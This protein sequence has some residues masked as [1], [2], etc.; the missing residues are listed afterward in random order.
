[1][2]LKMHPLNPE[3]RLVHKIITCLK[4]KG[5]IIYP[6]DTVYGI[7]CSI[8]AS[9]AIEKICKLKH[10]APNKA[11]L[12]IIFADLKHISD[13]CKPFNTSV[14][15]TLKAYLPGPFTFILEAN[16]N[17]PK[18]LL[19]NRRTIGIRIP[20]NI[21]TNRLVK[22]LEHPIIT[23]SLP[24]DPELTYI[25]DPEAL[26]DKY[27]NQV[28]YVIDGGNGTSQFS[29]IV[30]VTVSPPEIIRQGIGIFS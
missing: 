2:L 27:Q 17:I 12:S 23:A 25:T 22:E 6:T 7:G 3:P 15:R 29:T 20:N 14:F 4:N 5:T 24:Q 19:S 16:K 21:I 9:E 30:D 26:Y 28:D 1:M 10:I 8:Y 11:M 18:I 13:F